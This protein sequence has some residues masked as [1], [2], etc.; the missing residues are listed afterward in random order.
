MPF[1]AKIA[2]VSLLAFALL[3]AG[4]APASAHLLLAKDGRIHA[5]Y[6]AKGKGKGTIR[7][8]RNNKVRCPRKWRKVS[9]VATSLQGVPGPQGAQGPQGDRGQPG[10]AGVVSV[11][12]LES[13]V[14]ELLTRVESLEGILKGITNASLK[15][16]IGAIPVVESLC[17]EAEEL[18]EQ[19]TALG[20]TLGSLGSVLEVAL[21]AFKAPTV[22]TALPS[23]SCPSL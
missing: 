11:E 13:K 7:V 4:A 3:A 15:E 1:R 10:L 20:N 19:T 14:G 23:F 9:W 17:G 21:L 5:C 22:P 16:A 6:K 18:N 12:E 8:V 2:C